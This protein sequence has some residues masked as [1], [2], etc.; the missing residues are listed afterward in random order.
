MAAAGAVTWLLR[1]ALIVFVP[2]TAV[3]ARVAA[4]L[5]YAAPAAFASLAV[6][7][8]TAAA[9]DTGGG[10][11]AFAVATVVAAL[12]A[13]RSRNLMLTIAVGTARDRPADAPL[14]RQR[15]RTR[16]AA[17]GQR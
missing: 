13:Y 4:M 15:D 3:T 11:W 8:V 1:A 10:R 17:A 9:D 14:T 7:T 16:S 12:V 5:R 2:A 6:P